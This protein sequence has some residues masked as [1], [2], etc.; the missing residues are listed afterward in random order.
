MIRL[1][2]VGERRPVA[3]EAGWRL[4]CR[5]AVEE[6]AKLTTM[7]HFLKFNFRELSKLDEIERLYFCASTKNFYSGN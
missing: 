1:V 6:L 4:S 5:S 3:G 7:V 2:D